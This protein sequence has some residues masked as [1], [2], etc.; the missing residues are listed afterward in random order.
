MPDADE[1]REVSDRVW[2]AGAAAI[3]IAGALLRLYDLD[4]V[5]LHHDEGVNGN[6][7]KLLVRD[8]VYQYDPENYHGPTLFY[9]SAI[10]PWISRLLPGGALG[11]RY[12]L[13][14]FTMRFVPAAFGI[15]TIGLILLLRK[16]MG[17]IAV[18]TAAGALAV[19]PGAVY[20]SRYFI[21]E[22]LLVFFTLAA[23]IVALKFHETAKA[24]Y[25]L[26]LA[27]L[28]G[29]VFATKETAIITAGV[30]VVAWA[31]TFA[32]FRKPSETVDPAEEESQKTGAPRS[33]TD[34]SGGASGVGILALAG[35]SVFVAV[36]IL[37]YSS[38][39]TNYPKGVYDAVKTFTHWSKTGTQVHT[40]PWSTYLVWMWRKES[41]L[42][43]LGLAGIALALWRRRDRFAVFTA[44]W[45]LGVIA[46]YSIIPY[47]TP[48]LMLNFLLP[49]ALSS[50]RL[51]QELSTG[52]RNTARKLIPLAIAFAA[53][54]LS[55]YQTIRLNFFRY[56]DPSQVYVYVHTVREFLPLVD[57]IERISKQAG[58]GEQT[59]ILITA[60]E[61]W[62]LPW[63]LRN[64]SRV[65]YH[66]GLVQSDAWI[67][68][69]SMDQQP[70]LQSFLGERYILVK[71]DA[72]PI[73]SFTLRPGHELVLFVRRDVAEELPAANGYRVGSAR[74][75]G[76]EE[77]DPW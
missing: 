24:G 43:L 8:G 54:G 47:K 30:L 34:R 70:N 49:L 59:E 7:V 4:L 40:Q 1:K 77:P 23:V 13:T 67:V 39:F 58:T 31:M 64:Y 57:Q 46:A 14:T 48:W 10:I 42:L 29:L 28:A 21:H 3:L 41:T 63:Y 65:S 72:N 27:G 73:G 19:S 9:L 11:D 32:V 68:V 12:G 62:P 16:R 33:I 18:L 25:L 44:L 71:S 76:A 74:I 6:F 5:P 38:F 50:G 66:N 55:I 20:L 61:Y 56:D 26:L 53:L 75:A 15:A 60:R 52:A 51:L 69:G 2:R 22:S 17:K 45:A 35:L 36:N 37:L